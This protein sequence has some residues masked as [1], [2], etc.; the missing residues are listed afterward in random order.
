MDENNRISFHFHPQGFEDKTHAVEKDEGGQK[1]RYLRGIASGKSIDGHGE[2]MTD[3]AITS[4]QN[5]AKSGNI[6]L[7][8]GQHGVN[9]IDDIGK[10]TGSNITRGGDW[11]TEFRLYDEIDK[12]GGVT[13]EKADKL[14]R[15]VT[16]LPPYNHPVQKGFSIEGDIPD[17]G[18]VSM[19][20][21]G[22]RV[23]DDVALDGVLVVPRPAYKDS[24]ASAV[25]KALGLPKPWVIQKNLGNTL[26]EKLD[27]DDARDL[28]FKKKY[29]IDEALETEVRSIMSGA[30]PDY[31]EPLNMLFDEYRDLMV[32]IIM[33]SKELF[34]EESVDAI[35]GHAIYR[36]SQSTS[37]ELFEK[38]RTVTKQL[39]K[40]QEG[41]VNVKSRGKESVGKRKSSNLGD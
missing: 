1:R 20:Q 10:L 22:K 23:I 19:D 27:E 38:L 2:R 31:R 37:H 29:Q 12:M 30:Y 33:E 3:K 6:L 35:S 36:T 26:R 39:T 11:E 41:K 32:R 16:G 34:L 8:E 18:I 9:Y 7:Y 25:Y 40:I 4:F 5:Q 24:I 13:L 28:Y 15:Q 14:W 17:G 21:S